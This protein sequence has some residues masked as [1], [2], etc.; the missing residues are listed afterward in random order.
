MGRTAPRTLFGALVADR[1]RGACLWFV[2]ALGLT[3]FV[4][5]SQSVSSSTKPDGWEQSS[6]VDPSSP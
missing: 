5:S 6:V 4:V 1:G 3:V 2:G